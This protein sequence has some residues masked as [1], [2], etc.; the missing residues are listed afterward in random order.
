MLSGVEHSS[1]R[2]ASERAAPVITVRVD[3][4][5][6]I[7][8]EDLEN[9]L[10][11]VIASMGPPALVHCQAANHEVGTTQPLAEVVEI[12]ESVVDM[13]EVVATTYVYE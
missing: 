5:G 6:R 1:V 2:Q 4:L 12:L 8:T 13:R 10:D 11:E 9:V 3:G 7:V